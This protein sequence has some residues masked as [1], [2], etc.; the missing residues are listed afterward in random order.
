M[1]Y[2]SASHWHPIYFSMYTFC[3]AIAFLG[4]AYSV[5]YQVN[6]ADKGELIHAAVF[7]GSDYLLNIILSHMLDLT[8]GPKMLV[9]LANN[10]GLSHAHFRK[11]CAFLTDKTGMSQLR[12]LADIRGK[13]K[14]YVSKY[15]SRSV[16]NHVRTIN[17]F[18]AY[19]DPDPICPVCGGQ[20]KYGSPHFKGENQVYSFLPCC[21]IVTHRICA[22]EYT[23][24]WSVTYD[25]LDETIVL[26][27]E[28]EC[29]DCKSVFRNGRIWYQ[30]PARNF[31]RMCQN[32]DLDAVS[33][34]VRGTDHW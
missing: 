17:K 4:N 1:H 22:L 7:L 31:R 2:P 15:L 14:F 27:A 5:E 25:F 3:A 23:T 30:S 12:I 32:I 26:P 20:I 34:N 6:K 19:Q 33:P 24:D 18:W 8:S 21:M 10:F 28:R 13:D 16:R 11:V 9:A 29:P